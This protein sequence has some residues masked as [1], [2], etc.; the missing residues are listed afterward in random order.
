MRSADAPAAAADPQREADLGKAYDARIMRRL[1][2]YIRPWRGWFWA[3]MLCL[4]LTS[5]CSLAQP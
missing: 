3:A 1:W 5:A 4:P 2:V